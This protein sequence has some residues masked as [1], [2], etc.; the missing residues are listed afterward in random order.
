[1]CTILDGMDSQKSVV[2]HFARVPKAFTAAWN[3]C[4][5]VEGVLN[6]G[7]APHAQAYLSPP[8]V[9]KGASLSIETLM[10]VLIHQKET[11]GYVPPTWYIQADNAPSEFKNSV[12][13]LFLGMLVQVGIF[14]KV[15][16]LKFVHVL[17]FALTFILPLPFSPCSVLYILGEGRV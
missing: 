9:G 8:T 16:R 5:H 12:C 6:H 14:K 11:N 13:L 15:R 17:P 1:M 3:M 7:H 4:F 10:R 2:P